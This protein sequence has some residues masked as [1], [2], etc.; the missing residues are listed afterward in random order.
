MVGIML[1]LNML[2][3]FDRADC[4]TTVCGILAIFFLN[5]NSEVNREKFRYLPVCILV[6]IIYDIVW[7][8][9]I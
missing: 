3:S 4:V 5:D 6:S 9:I 1:I 7:L 2:A 8:F